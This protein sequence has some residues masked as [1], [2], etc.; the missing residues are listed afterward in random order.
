MEKDRFSQKIVHFAAA[1]CDVYKN[2]DAKDSNYLLPLEF[3]EESLTEDFTAMIYAQ[4]VL[5]KSITNADI[6]IL[7]FSHIV[8][9]LIFQHVL[10]DNGVDLKEEKLPNEIS[11]FK[12]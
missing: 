12:L 4:W 6:D 11:Q 9:R 5:Y 3:S 2:S 8:N 1:L 10:K 7:G